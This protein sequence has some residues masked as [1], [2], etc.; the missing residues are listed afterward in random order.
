MK[1][2]FIFDLDGT[3]LDSLEDIAVSANKVLKELGLREIEHKKYGYLVG[4]GVDVLIENISKELH[5]ALDAKD[6]V[7]RFK[8]VYENKMQKSTKPYDG[9]LE[10]LE[11]L[12]GHNLAVL[13]NKTHDMTKQYVQEFFPNTFSQIFGQREGVPKKPNP[14]AVDEIISYFKADKKDVYF[15]GDTNVDM[16][17]GN[18]AKVKTIGVLWGFRDEKELRENNADFIVKHPLDILETVKQDG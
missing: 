4:G 13:S 7:K 16:Q 12:K 15:V 5:V 10:L 6:V 18:N 2:T 14:Q 17:T 1:K 3:L 11:K 9:I 8:R